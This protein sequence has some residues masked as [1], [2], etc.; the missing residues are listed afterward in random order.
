[1]LPTLSTPARA[2]L[3]AALV[4]GAAVSRPTAARAQSIAPERALRNRVDAVPSM[5]G[6]ATATAVVSDD[7]VDGERALLNHSDAALSARSRQPFTAQIEVADAPSVDG[8]KA[9][10]NRASS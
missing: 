5:A 10:L 9:L 6:P 8:V 2:L 7:P 1:M 4:G 3:L